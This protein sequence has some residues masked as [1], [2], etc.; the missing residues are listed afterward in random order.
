MRGC[1]ALRNYPPIFGGRAPLKR[2]IL[3]DCSNLLTLPLDIH[4]L[5]QLE[6]LD[7]RGCVN[8]SRLPSLIAQLP[9]NCIILVPP[10]LQAQLDQHRPV[11]RPAEPGRTGPTTPALSPSAAGDRAGPSSS[12]TASELLR[13]AALERIEHTA[14]AMLSTVIDE[15]RNPFLEGAPSYLPG[16]RPADATT[17]G[18]VP[19][20]RDML[21]ESRDLEFLQRVSDMA[22]PSPESKT[23]ARKAS[24]ATTRTSATGRRRRA[25][26][27]ASSIISGSSFITK[28]A[29]ST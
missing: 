11:A 3:K 25:R 4:R 24:P 2:L 19:A 9:A 15:E 29:R 7:L 17:F 27:W 18:Q 10:H 1:T 26:T 13:T 16:R 8:L 6:K 14:Q 23:R 5:T 28:E 22:G 21:A 20:L 12:A